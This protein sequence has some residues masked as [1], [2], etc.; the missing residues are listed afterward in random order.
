MTSTASRRPATQPKRAADCLQRPLVP[1]S[2][3]RQQL[4]PSVGHAYI[5]MISPYVSSRF[6]SQWLRLALGSVGVA[7]D[8]HPEQGQRGKEEGHTDHHK[9]IAKGGGNR[10]NVDVPFDRPERRP[11]CSAAHNP[12]LVQV[13]LDLIEGR[14]S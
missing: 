5:L 11:I 3:F 6:T 9:A 4:T 7:P 2:R 10:F 1:R 13:V 14:P 12:R 8:H